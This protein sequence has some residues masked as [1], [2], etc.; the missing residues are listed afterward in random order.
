MK[1]LRTERIKI[2]ISYLPKRYLSIPES[3]S[4][5][6]LLESERDYDIKLSATI[7]QASS[8]QSRAKKPPRISQREPPK[9][10]VVDREISTNNCASYSVSGF[11]S[12]G[13]RDR[14]CRISLWWRISLRWLPWHHELGITQTES[15]VLRARNTN[16]WYNATS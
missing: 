12:P 10:L 4:N 1:H 7:D 16:T 14:K 3:D 2:L 13:H 5:F 8:S 9:S 11:R 6:T 15:I